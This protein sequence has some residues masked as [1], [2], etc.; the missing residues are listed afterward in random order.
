MTVETRPAHTISR[1][2]GSVDYG[3]A[4]DVCSICGCT[5]SVGVYD[6]PEAPCYGRLDET[7]RHG[8]ESC[9]QC[10]AST[11]ED[12]E[13]TC[14]AIVLPRGACDCETCTEAHD[15]T[16]VRYV[17]DSVV[18]YTMCML[19]IDNGAELSS[20]GSRVMQRADVWCRIGTEPTPAVA[21]DLSTLLPQLLADAELAS[22]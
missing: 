1:G 16:G 7:L 12:C 2:G 20:W 10:E 17:S 13:D 11:Y 21:R 19:A 4:F 18:D 3:D 14:E 6:E 5:W 22:Y 8:V 9:S 15:P